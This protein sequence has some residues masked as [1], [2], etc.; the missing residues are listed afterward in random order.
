[1]KNCLKSDLLIYQCVRGRESSSSFLDEKGGE[2]ALQFPFSWHIYPKKLYIYISKKL[3]TKLNYTYH[4][5]SNKVIK[6]IKTRHDTKT[7]GQ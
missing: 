6:K 3:L 4:H 2:A 1:M 5:N 7:G